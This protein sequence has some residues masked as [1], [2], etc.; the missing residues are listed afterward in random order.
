MKDT[1]FAFIFSISL[2]LLFPSATF[3][4]PQVELF[5]ITA[6]YSPLAGQSAYV[7]GD[8]KTDQLINGLGFMSASGAS[9]FDGMVAA[10]QGLSFGT[11]LYI[12]GR[13]W[14]MV[15][16]RGGVIEGK[17]ENQRISRLD[18]WTGRGDHGRQEAMQWG[19]RTG[20]VTIFSD[21]FASIPLHTFA[22]NIDFDTTSQEV[23]HLQ[24]YL[25][26]LGFF[27]HAI[28]GWYGEVTQQAVLDFQLWKGIIPNSSY[29]GAG[30]VGPGTRTRLNNITAAVKVLRDQKSFSAQKFPPHQQ[31]QQL[32]KDFYATH[33]VPGDSNYYVYMLQ[34][35][36]ER[37]GYFSH[38]HTTFDFGKKTTEAI[39][40]FQL[41]KGIIT[42]VDQ[43]GAGQFG[44]TTR[45]R[46]R[47]ALLF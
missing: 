7:H 13:G 10:P 44:P 41:D 17:D 16:D 23:K 5:E 26:G 34:S 12:E 46:L 39:L 6:Y 4:A 40:A 37:L 3:A 43:V 30:R 11:L 38:P 9:P 15:D 24:Q 35:R 14:H 31:N 28:T 33:L 20:S 25:K 45:S 22:I 18:I 42:A 1:L 21:D 8:Y 2:V 47:Q 36:L 29:T 27:D 19:R 32:I